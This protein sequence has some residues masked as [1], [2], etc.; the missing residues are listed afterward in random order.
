[1]LIEIVRRLNQ[2]FNPTQIYLFG[3]RSKNTHNSESDYDLFLIVEHTEL[4]PIQRMQKAT[5]LLWD[6]NCK[7]DTFIYTR[8][9]YNLWK[10]ELNSI[11]NTAILEG[12]ELTFG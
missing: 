7:V 4:R 5:R 12:T 3:S 6:I 11:P 2:E 8:N 1:N 9:E 10:D